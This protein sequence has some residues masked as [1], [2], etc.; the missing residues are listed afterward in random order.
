MAFVVVKYDLEEPGRQRQVRLDEARDAIAVSNPLQVAIG[1][2]GAIALVGQRQVDPVVVLGRV[3]VD[4]RV[5]LVV[6]ARADEPAE[7]TCRG[8]WGWFGRQ[9]PYETRPQPQQRG[10]FGGW[11]GGGRW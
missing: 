4:D 5:A 1:R 10:F 9:Q 8:G 2:A 7:D 11:F 6:V 3:L